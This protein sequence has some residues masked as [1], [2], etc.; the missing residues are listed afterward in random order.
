M[1]SKLAPD[2]SAGQRDDQPDSILTIRGMSKRIRIVY[3]IS[4]LRNCGPTTQLYNLISH[5]DAKLFDITVVTLSPESKFS[6]WICFNTLGITLYSLRKNRFIRF[7]TLVSC[8]MPL[9]NQLKPN[10]V[11]TQGIRADYLSNKLPKHFHRITTQRN[12]PT[13]DYTLQYGRLIGLP[14]GHIHLRVISKIPNIVACSHSIADKLEHRNII[15]HTI[16]NGVDLRPG[17]HLATKEERN[18]HRIHLGLSTSDLIFVFTGPLI[19]RKRPAHLI[20]H[21]LRFFSGTKATLC[22]VGDGPMM[23]QCKTVSQNSS[24]IVFVGFIKDVTP[25]LISANVFVSAALSEGLPNSVLEAL[26]WGLPVILSGIPPHEE[27]LRL[28]PEAGYLVDLDSIE[29][30]FENFT[31]DYLTE[32]RRFAARAIV[33][34]Y[35]NAKTMADEYSTLY[36]TLINSKL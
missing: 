19:S 13:V 26:S 20:S 25:Y 6:R 32:K 29:N 7:S 24:Q 3:I 15:A 36:H 8:L 11:H 17:Q 33:T 23:S 27:I 9:L 18:R 2:E 14:L 16:Q 22:I 31:E 10:I 30:V 4:S 34:N 5:L 28:G 12:V 35:L 21:F 1:A